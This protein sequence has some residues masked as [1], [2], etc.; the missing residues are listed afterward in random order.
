MRSGRDGRAVSEQFELFVGID[1]AA[2]NHEVCVLNA[3]RRVIDRKTVEHSG[4][5]VAQ[6]CDLLLKLSNRQPSR[7]AVAIETPRGAVVETLVERQFAVFA[8]N[9]KQMHRFRDRHSMAGAKDDRKDAF[10]L[11]DSLRTDRHLFH[12]VQLDG[13]Q[14]IRIRELSRTEE[15]I[16]QQQIRAGNQLR[17]L[18]RRYYPQMLNLC[19]GVDEVWF[20]DLIECAPKPEAVRQLTRSKIERL[21]KEHRIRR[22]SA[23]EVLAALKAPP[24]QLAPGAVE[25]VSDHVLM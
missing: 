8:I 24:L 18:L 13:A 9:P 6:L 19:P 16:V 3:E 17:E 23:E 25:A 1:W 5:G 20:W 15:D 10:V 2:E 14:V 11:S 12:R 4:A 7:V 22:L 21:L